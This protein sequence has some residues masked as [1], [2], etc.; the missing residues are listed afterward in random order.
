M[1]DVGYFLSSDHFRWTFS[2]VEQDK[3][4]SKH[5][6]QACKHQTKGQGV[7]KAH[8]ASGVVGVEGKVVVVC[9]LLHAGMGG[10]LRPGESGD[11][12]IPQGQ[13][14]LVSPGKQT[15]NAV[16]NKPGQDSVHQ[17]GRHDGHLS[18]KAQGRPV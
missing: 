17:S 14:P 4:Q 10:I 12:L 16:E 18:G 3:Q 1:E 2:S 6:P 5:Q 9:R 11:R 13:Q 7:D 8:R 15:G